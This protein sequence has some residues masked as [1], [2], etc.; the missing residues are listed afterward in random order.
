VFETADYVAVRNFTFWQQRYV[1][2]ENQMTDCA[3]EL[4]VG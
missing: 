4:K 2:H 3:A 1:K